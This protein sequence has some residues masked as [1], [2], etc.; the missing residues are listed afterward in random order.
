MFLKNREKQF[1]QPGECVAEDETRRERH[2]PGVD[3]LAAHAPI[4]GSHAP[5]RTHT[6]DG[7]AD[8]MSGRKGNSEPRGN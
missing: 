5:D 2:Q 6:H 8:G 4:D 3:D 1:E 7:S